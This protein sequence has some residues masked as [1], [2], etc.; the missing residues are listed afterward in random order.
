MRIDHRK[1]R[2]SARSRGRVEVRDEMAVG[3]A[4]KCRRKVLRCVGSSSYTWSTSA[5][6]PGS[7][8]ARDV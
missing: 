4:E 1:T 3:Q 7:R 8:V 5:F 2:Q 6:N